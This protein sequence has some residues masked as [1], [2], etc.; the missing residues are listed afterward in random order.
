[1]PHHGLSRPTLRIQQH[2]GRCNTL[3]MS[4][5][6]VLRRRT[7]K[8]HPKRE[9]QSRTYRMENEEGM[10]CKN[11]FRVFPYLCEKYLQ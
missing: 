2:T 3:K 4:E 11:F 7:H 8:S 1:M 9:A 10:K 6:G 5:N